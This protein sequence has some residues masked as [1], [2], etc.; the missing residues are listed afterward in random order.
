M[1]YAPVINAVVILS[2]IRF[3]TACPGSF[4]NGTDW[5][6]L[7]TKSAIIKADP[8]IPFTASTLYSHVQS[9]VNFQGNPILNSNLVPSLSACGQCALNYAN[10]LLTIRDADSMDS[11]C[12][13]RGEVWSRNDTINILDSPCVNSIQSSLTSFNR[14]SDV[15]YSLLTGMPVETQCSYADFFDIDA[16][17]HSFGTMMSYALNLTSPYLDNIVPFMAAVEASS[18]GICFLNFMDSISAARSLTSVQQLCV[19]DSD[20]IYTTDC[21]EI[22][23]I[24]EAQALFR[25]CV[26]GHD[27]SGTAP[28]LCSR[29]EKLLIT[30]AYNIYEPLVECSVAN[31]PLGD[32]GQITNWFD[33]IQSKKPEL[34]QMLSTT[35]TC[36]ECLLYF[37]SFVANHASPT[38]ESIGP[39]APACIAS[40]QTGRTN[41]YICSGLQISIAQPV[42]CPPVY[43]ANLDPRYMSYIP[44]MEIGMKANGNLDKAIGMFFNQ[45]TNSPLLNVTEYLPCRSCYP[46][47]AAD[48]TYLFENSP[49]TIADCNSFY[50]TQCMESPAV[51]SALSDFE[52]CSGFTLDNTSPY[53]CFKS[54]VES[55]QRLNLPR[56]L[57]YGMFGLGP[58]VVSP[59]DVLSGVEEAFDYLVSQS[60]GTNTYMC[61]TCFERL[62]ADLGQ[63][64]SRTKDICD[65]VENIPI[66][67]YEI[68]FDLE[69]FTA[70]SGFDFDFSQPPVSQV[71]LVSPVLNTTQTQNSTETEEMKSTNTETKGSVHSHAFFIA[72]ILY[73]I[74]FTCSCNFRFLTQYA[75]KI[76]VDMNSV[77]SKRF[78]STLSNKLRGTVKWFDTKKGF[79]FIASPEAQGDV[80]VHQSNIISSTGFRSLKDGMEVAFVLRPDRAGKNQAYEVSSP[81]G[82]P[83]VISTK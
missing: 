29:E 74:V 40:I 34:V 46:S 64:D 83:V 69:R 17:F 63:V 53:T 51:S 14:C 75:K 22:Q 60:P 30:K 49:Q 13:Q 81:D 24:R 3:T 77:L 26:G 50:N 78:A 59:I 6:L 25:N 72:P 23:A 36:R 54:E 4:Y 16:Q 11:S 65:S 62:H 61:R 79:G 80:F 67:F 27:M 38:C 35:L 68:G 10:S 58:Q 48:F 28:P 19:S 5:Y 2:I 33:C 55:I 76:P 56:D 21:G 12:F 15:T 32:P 7:L 45:S 18:C 66:C 1:S 37:G 20:G 52:V 47:L 8:S 9:D 43:L 42:V 39:Y 31:D 57:Y 73:L 71:S 70:C 41:A 82:S 44:M